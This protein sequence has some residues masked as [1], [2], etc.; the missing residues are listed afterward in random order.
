MNIICLGGRIVGYELARDLVHT[1]LK[2]LF[3]GDERFRRRL[4]KV[5][6]LEVREEQQ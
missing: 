5:E 1:F 3:K 6:K 4:R 2:A